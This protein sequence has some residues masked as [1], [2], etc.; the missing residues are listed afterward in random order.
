MLISINKC[1][2]LESKLSK[3]HINS[4]CPNCNSNLKVKNGHYPSSKVM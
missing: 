4:T 1:L 3:L 2:S